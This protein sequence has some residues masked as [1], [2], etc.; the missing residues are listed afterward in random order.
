MKIDF[1]IFLVY[2]PKIVEGCLL[3]LFICAIALPIA[4]ILGLFVCLA[5]M[6]KHAVPRNLA[7]AFIEV[8]RNTP[9]LIQIFLAFY[10]LPFYGVRMAPMTAGIACL[11]IYGSAYF[12]EIIR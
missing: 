11:C 12:A 7:L 4:F 3:T 6:S 9:F 5:R 2:W 8:I 1:N 10:V